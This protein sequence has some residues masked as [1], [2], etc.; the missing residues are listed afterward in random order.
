MDEFKEQAQ[1]IIATIVLILL[2]IVAGLP[3][4][5]FSHFIKGVMLGFDG[6]IELLKWQLGE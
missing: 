2:W 3:I 5:I 6:F 4:L 1:L